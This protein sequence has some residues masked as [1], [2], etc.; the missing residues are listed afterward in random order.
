[1][2]QENDEF[3]RALADPTRRDLLDR[4]RTQDGQTLAALGEG[5][6]MSRQSMTQHLDV[7]A[8]AGLVT[9]VHRGR[10]RLHYLN[11]EPIHRLQSRWL[12]AFDQPRLDALESIRNQ[13]EEIA[14][15]TTPTIPEYVYVT[16]I[17][18]S[19]EQIWQA[20]TDADLTAQYWRHRNVSTWQAGSTWEHLNLTD[21]PV[22]EVTG[23]VL[24]S[25]PPTRLQV[26][27]EPTEH[28]PQERPSV[29][30]FSVEPGD[31]ITR[32]VVTHENLASE[33]DLQQISHGWPAVLA[34][35]KSLLE[36]GST[37]PQDPWTMPPSEPQPSTKTSDL[38][39][40]TID[41]V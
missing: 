8:H 34:N 6:R 30:T 7:L 1:M 27:F 25:E 37:L 3:F 4:L 10:L 18:A 33:V 22:A 17:K 23:R 40:S 19:A 38:A 16:Y 36:T 12:A 35:L 11:P 31:D 41:S 14:M 20:L 24:L 32:L 26:T 2:T 15:A 13:A 39:Y 5:V 21:P 29:V 28:F 9:V